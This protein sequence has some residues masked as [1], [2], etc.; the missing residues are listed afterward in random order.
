MNEQ[1]HTMTGAWA[2]N[3]L[4]A[5]EREQVRR[6]LAE[7]PEAAAEAAAF[8][9]TAAELAGSLPPL[10]PRPE[11][12][13]AVMARIGTT[14]QLS[15]LPEEEDSPQTDAASGEAPAVAPGDVP[16][17]RPVA[18]AAEDITAPPSPPAQVVSLDRFRASRRS[19]RWTA[20]AAAALLLTTI[21][22]AGLWN[23]ERIAEQEARAS[24]AAMASEQASAEAERAML[25]TIL[26]SD[27]AAHLAIPSQ[28]G[29]SLQLLYSREQGAMFVQAAD[30]PTLPADKAYQLWMIDD[31][32]I[33]SAGM[34]E[35]PAAAVIHDGAIPEGVTVGLT[36]EPAGGSAQP[37]MDPIAAGVLS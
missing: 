34:L 2:L 18:G 14:R 29:G 22:G 33:A 27:D 13:A 15:P 9:E 23:S 12:K 1:K 10:A 5:E 35:E 37:T 31:S 25:S 17:P 30:L 7:D 21:A 20:V 11:L 6:Y 3:A 19:N 8:E 24:L 32:G 4:D 36:I 28:D 16:S 26:A